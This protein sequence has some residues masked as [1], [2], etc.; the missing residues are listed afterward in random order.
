MRHEADG[1]LTVLAAAFDGKALNS[2]NDLA[3]RADGSVW[4]T[5]PTY[6]LGK[7]E[8]GVAGTFVYR[9]GADQQVRV[10][11]REFDMPNGICFSPDHRR[12][13]IADSG[14]SQRIGAFDVRDDGSLAPAAL[15]IAQGSDGM[16]CDE[17]GNLYTTNLKGVVVFDSTGKELLVIELEQIPTNLCFGGEDGHTLFITARTHLYRIATKVAGAM[18]PPAPPA[19][20]APAAKDGGVQPG[21]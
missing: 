18:M 10:V 8:R 17:H 21:K 6:G 14:R 20:A 11:Q 5:D 19:P 12:V 7:R 3:V 2:P 4:F 15:W 16:R 13:Y 9:L 1:K